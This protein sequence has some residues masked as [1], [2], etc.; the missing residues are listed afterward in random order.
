MPSVL[1]EVEAPRFQDNL[2]MTVIRL[3]ARCTGHLYLPGNIPGAHCCLRLSQPQ[4]HS[5]TGRIMSSKNSNDTIR[6][7]TC[8]LPACNVEHQPSV[9]HMPLLFHV[10]SLNHLDTFS[11]FH[12]FHTF[13]GV[14]CCCSISPFTL[15][16]LSYLK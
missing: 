3:S 15:V 11:A 10:Q 2:H 9:H 13:L 5:A 8:D 1:H 16:F 12:Y 14:Q 7:R 4:G 6:N